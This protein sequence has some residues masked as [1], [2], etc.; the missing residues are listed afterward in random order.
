MTAPWASD[1][2]SRARLG[3]GARVLDAACGTGVVAREA[4]GRAGVT[5][6]VAA[7][8]INPGMLAVARSPGRSPLRMA[9]PSR[10]SA[11]ACSRCRFP[12]GSS[13]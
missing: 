1:L 12:T 7:L 6:R 3:P 5:G 11:P 10:G 13:T 9:R 2:A 8:D 4:A